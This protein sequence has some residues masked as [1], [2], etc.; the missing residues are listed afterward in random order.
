MEKVVDGIGFKLITDR[1]VS[2]DAQEDNRNKR[3]EK[4]K[5]NTLLS[6]AFSIPVFL[7]SMVFHNLP[8]ANWIM[9][10][11]AAPVLAIFGREFFIIAWKRA[12]HLSSN[13]DTLVALGTGTA[14]L[15]SM[16]NT[17]FPGFLKITGF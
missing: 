1:S 8:Y 3:L 4:L 9:L 11:L 2:P 10:I 7:I 16:F 13:M 5:T 12:I 15:Y 6:I 17:I 14:F